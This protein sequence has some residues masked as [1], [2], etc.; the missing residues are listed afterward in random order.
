MISASL[1]K[2]FCMS[3]VQLPVSTPST[4][5]NPP[6]REKASW[7]LSFHP[8]QPPPA[9]LPNEGHSKRRSSLHSSQL[10]LL[11]GHALFSA[12]RVGPTTTAPLSPQQMGGVS[13]LF[14]TVAAS[15]YPHHPSPP[16]WN[17]VPASIALLHRLCQPV[18]A[19]P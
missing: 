18:L 13:C 16:S 15:I 4:V 14:R 2:L 5:L 6:C 19:H 7:A 9:P 12:V 10:F 1:E 11:Q 8:C 17:G 3:A